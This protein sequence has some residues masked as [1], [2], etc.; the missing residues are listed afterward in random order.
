M[1][2]TRFAKSR[3]CD[4]IPNGEVCQAC[5]NPCGA[6]G[7]DGGSWVHLDTAPDRVVSTTYQY[8]VWVET[9]LAN[10]VIIRPKGRRR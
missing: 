2:E 5:G 4:A 10:G 9:R 6:S 8:G 7:C 1:G 3:R